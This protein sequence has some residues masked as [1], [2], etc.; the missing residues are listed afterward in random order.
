MDIFCTHYQ[1][2][3][4][5]QEGRLYHVPEPSLRKALPFP[6]ASEALGSLTWPCPY[7][8][9]RYTQDFLCSQQPTKEII[10]S[11]CSLVNRW[12]YGGCSQGHRSLEH[13]CYRNATRASMGDSSPSTTL[14]LPVRHAGSY[15]TEE[16]PF[17]YQFFASYIT[18]GKS[19]TTQNSK[20]P[21]PLVLVSG[22]GVSGASR[23][24]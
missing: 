14:E 17:D 11:K 2:S 6:H 20:F 18:L 12:L 1:R 4:S 16:T 10:P 22:V 13:L 5:D 3:H 19:L 15:T 7:Q 8:Q 24:P 23:I 9:H 21:E